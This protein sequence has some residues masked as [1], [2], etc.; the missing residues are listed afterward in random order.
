MPTN[1]SRRMKAADSRLRWA[2]VNGDDGF[3][4][5]ELLVVIA[6]IAIL[7]ALLLPALGKAKDQ[8]IRTDCKNNERQQILALAMYAHDN[9][10]FLPD[11][12]GAHQPWDMTF[13]IGTYMESAGAPYKIWYDPGAFMAYTDADLLQFWNN[14][15]QE[16][17]GDD[18]LRVVGY[19]ETFYGIGLYAD[20]GSWAFSTNVNQKLSAEVSTVSNHTFRL[21]A[22]SR[23]LLACSTITLPGDI[24]DNYRVLG[25]FPWTDIPHSTD[26]DVPVMKS[27]TSAHLLGARLPAGANEGMIDG[28]VEWR[29]FRQLLPRAGSANEGPVFYY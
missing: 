23:V 11:D 4:L 22:S 26:P 18:V 17:F 8:A 29:P 2:F 19:A 13:A 5:I 28:H 27:F 7:A 1:Q 25:T 3:T 16:F 15:G 21:N 14:A 20:F 24:S 6:V 10:D 9:K 12:T